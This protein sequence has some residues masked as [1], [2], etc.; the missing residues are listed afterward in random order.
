M[1][2]RELVEILKKQAPEETACSWDNV[3]LQLGDFQKEVNKVYIALDAEDHVITHT[4]ESGADFLL[5]HHPLIFKGIK[6]INSDHFIGRRILKMAENGVAYYAMHTNFD[7]HGM[8]ELSAQKLGLTDCEVLETEY[9]HDG[10]EEGIGRVGYFEKPVTLSEC[11]ERVKKA[12]DIEM[13]KVFGNPDSKVHKIALSPGSGKSVILSAQKKG[14]DVLI[15]GDIDHHEGID[16]V[17]SKM[18][19]IDAGHYGIEHI[20]VDYMKEYLQ[21]NCP[22]LEIET[23]PHRQPFLYL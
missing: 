17:A 8:A 6:S 23:E 22:E 20:F 2:V 1:K 13:V 19:V 9:V 11:I 3:G 7:I 12:Y 16:A 15:T 14:A 5:T 10:I 4:L 21:K 18:A